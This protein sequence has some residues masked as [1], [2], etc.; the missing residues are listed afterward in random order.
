MPIAIDASVVGVID[1]IIDN[2]GGDG[3][4]IVSGLES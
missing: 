1:P 3:K 2:I 4:F